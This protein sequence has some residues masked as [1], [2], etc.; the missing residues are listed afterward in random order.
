MRPFAVLLCSCLLTVAAC[1][2]HVR[3]TP[4]VAT[5]AITREQAT[6]ILIHEGYRNITDLHQ[7]G[8]EWVGT[9][10]KRGK[11]AT[12]DIDSNGQVSLVPPRR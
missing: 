1:A 9:A 7:N 10:T 4:R 11:T 2:P 3:V 5:T 12:F 6:Q 8:E